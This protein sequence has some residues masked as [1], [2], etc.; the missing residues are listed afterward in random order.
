MY[1]IT[2][3]FSANNYVHGGGKSELTDKNCKQL[4]IATGAK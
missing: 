2:Y 3:N 4:Y 1:Q